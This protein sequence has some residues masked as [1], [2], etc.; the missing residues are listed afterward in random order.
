[1][2]RKLK[3]TS[4]SLPQTANC[5]FLSVKKKKKKTNME[6]TDLGYFSLPSSIYIVSCWPPLE[7]WDHFYDSC[8]KHNASSACYHISQRAMGPVFYL[9]RRSRK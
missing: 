6:I 3:A 5:D 9:L 4:V 7:Q 8:W 2:S 1:M